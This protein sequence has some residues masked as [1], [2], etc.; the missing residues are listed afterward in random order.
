MRFMQGLAIAGV[1]VVCVNLAFYWVASSGQD[2]IVP[3]YL[4]EAR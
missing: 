4:T 1:I 2:P 3:S